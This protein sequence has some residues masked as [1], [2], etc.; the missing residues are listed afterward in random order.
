MLGVKKL[1]STAYHPESQGLVERTNHSL[2]QC[3]SFFVSRKQDDWDQYLPLITYSI[4]TSVQD[5]IKQAP[6][7]AMFGR[8]PPLLTHF[9]FDIDYHTYVDEEDFA[10]E[11]R[12]RLQVI[13]KFIKENNRKAQSKMAKYYDEKASDCTYLEGDLVYIYNPQVAK[14]RSAKLSNLWYGP[15]QI[16]RA[17]HYPNLTIRSCAD[18]DSPEE[19]I[20]CNRAKRFTGEFGLLGLSL[21]LCTNPSEDRKCA[22]DGPPRKMKNYPN[23]NTMLQHE[24]ERLDHEGI[25]VTTPEAPK[26]ARRR[27]NKQEEERISNLDQ[28]RGTRT[29]YSLRERP[30]KRILFVRQKPR[31]ENIMTIYSILLH[32]RSEASALV[33]YLAQKPQPLKLRSYEATDEVKIVRVPVHDVDKFVRQHGHPPKYAIATL[34]GSKEYMAQV[35]EFILENVCNISHQKNKRLRLLI[36][37]STMKEFE[38]AIYQENAESLFF[39]LAEPFRMRG[40]SSEEWFVMAVMEDRKDQNK[41]RDVLYNYTTKFHQEIPHEYKSRPE[42][43]P[44]SVFVPT[45]LFAF[46][47]DGFSGRHDHEN[48]DWNIQKRSLQAFLPISQ[49]DNLEASSHSKADHEY[50][51]GELEGNQEEGVVGKEQTPHKADV[52]RGVTK[53]DNQKKATETQVMHPDDDQDQEVAPKRSPRKNKFSYVEPEPEEYQDDDDGEESDAATSPR[54]TATTRPMETMDQGSQTTIQLPSGLC[55]HHFCRDEDEQ[56]RCCG[57]TGQGGAEM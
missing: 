56:H 37:G 38:Q 5:S 40:F 36:L 43:Q 52:P 9:E 13:W 14:G 11:L 48:W 26:N 22:R 16:V 45:N 1:T 34:E 6:F 17:D 19:V 10:F 21:P 20:H 7:F 27:N 39:Y 28:S 24:R 8:I 57:H 49:Q 42:F 15:Y 53:N 12:R 30:T 54:E 46:L 33:Q 47:V 51:E 55:L 31:K 35:L 41:I 29:P 4:N 50:E 3:L 23:E 25:I 18:V 44:A 32:H 2:S